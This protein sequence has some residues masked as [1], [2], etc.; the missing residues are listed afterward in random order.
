MS[1]LT[2]LN[3][4]SWWQVSRDERYFCAELHHLIR[5]DTSRFIRH[6]NDAH[7]QK[8]NPEASWEVAYEACF[9]RD[10][11][12]A[13]HREHDR[14]S[15]KRTFDLALF[16]DDEILLIE[17]KAQQTFN[18]RQLET[19][20]RDAKYVQQRTGASRVRMGLLVSSHYRVPA[21]ALTSFEGPRL[22]WLELAHLYGDSPLLARADTL[23]CSPG[24]MS[25]TELI[26]ASEAGEDFLVGRD[27]GLGGAALKQDIESG[28]W[29]SCCYAMKREALQAPNRNW[30]SLR[31]FARAVA[32]RP[33]K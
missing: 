32:S 3:G 8:L 10:L 16:S 27:G 28:A 15:L 13:G 12:H 29:R 11:W 33:P 31:D 21:R 1:G 20:K 23:F 24:H 22:T 26:A 18:T 4:K 25:G 30:F 6:L 7:K 9:Y 14:V 5:N 17:A 19:F 2:W